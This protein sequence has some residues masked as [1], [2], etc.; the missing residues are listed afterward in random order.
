MNKLFS[1]GSILVGAMAIAPTMVGS[2]AVAAT[3][4]SAAYKPV[5]GVLEVAFFGP[6]TIAVG[7]AKATR[8]LNRNKPRR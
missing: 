7:L 2:A 6:R 4:N 3:G 1:A 5:K 8:H